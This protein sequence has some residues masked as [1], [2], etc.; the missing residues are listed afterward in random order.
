MSTFLQYKATKRLQELAKT[1]FDLT[2][3]GNLTP[4]RLT[5]FS[6]Q[7][8]GFK[9]LYGT[10]RVDDQTML[11]L[12]EL[13]AEAGVVNK[14]AQMQSGAHIN[15]IHRYPSEDRAV[16]HT[17]T[18]DFFENPQQ[19][20]DAKEAAKLAKQQVDKLESFMHEIDHENH[21]TDLVMIGIGGSD[22][23]PRAHYLA[24][25]HLQKFGRRAHFICNVDPDDAAM[26]FR[27]LNLSKTLVVVVS[28]TGTTL[29]TVTNEALAREQFKAAKLDSTRHFISVTMPGSPMDNMKLYR[30]SFHMWDWIGGRY[31]TTSMVGGV[32]LTFAFGFEVY[33][34]FL[35][36][37]HAMDQQVLTSIDLKQN[38]P[39]LAALLGIWNR[40]FLHYPTLAIIPYSQ[41]L[42]RY[43]AHIQQLDMES[44][45]KRIDKEGKVV[46][47]DTG[48]IIWGE[49]GT[50]AQHSFYQLIHQGTTIVPLEMIGFKES[51]LQQDITIEGTTSQ[52]KLLANLFAQALGLAIGQPNE[53]PNKVFPGNRPTHIL[54]GKRLTPY[55]LGTLLAFYEHKIAYQG[56]I[57]NI[58]SFDQE[59]VQLGKVLA[60]K[61]I[62]RFAGATEA[63]P[64]ADTLI[65]HLK[66]L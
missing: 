49:P 18:R 46:D 5:K 56:F 26:V 20:E 21:F 43:P 36:G 61:I 13:A 35:K 34:E 42:L 24:L 17:A 16:L 2:K 38:L 66:T 10:E 8:C 37:A 32:L 14:M 29:E 39:L 11:A 62:S 7:S 55:S 54:M 31:S 50:N 22:L 52:Q 19:A 53:N 47:F 41:E 58:N 27:N 28:K 25:Q 57:W 44:N 33:W 51:Q 48:P 1:P 40:N 15:F 9:L 60:N 30:A 59:G 64:L 4:E 12:S 63:Y 23:G 65:E 3:I 45:G 6:S